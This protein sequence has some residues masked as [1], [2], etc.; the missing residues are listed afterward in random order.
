MARIRTIKP[1][2]FFH[3]GVAALNPLTQLFFIGLWTQVSREGRCEDRPLMLRAN[4]FPYKPEIDAEELL[5]ELAAYGHIT[6]YRVKGKAY[7]EVHNFLKHQRPNH[8]EQK[9]DIPPAPP[10]KTTK[11][12]GKAPASPGKIRSSPGSAPGEREGERERRIMQGKEFTPSASENPAPEVVKP[13][14]PLQRVVGAY[15]IAKGNDRDDK[16]WDK[17]NF[18]RYSKAAKSL[19]DCFGGDEKAAVVYLLGRGQELD[20]KGL[21]WTLETI[22]RHAW[23]NKSKLTEGTDG[24]EH[25]KV[26]PDNLLGARRSSRATPAG[27]L[28]GGVLRELEEKRDAPAGLEGRELHRADGFEE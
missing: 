28:A 8:K 25:G 3:E 1:E 16:A 27:E 9:C 5:R 13:L 19:I 23:D 20:D 6:R 26:G 2:F 15:K 21:D 17:A 11:K 10:S 24:S 14:T 12:P 22:S 7:I 18:G 4:I